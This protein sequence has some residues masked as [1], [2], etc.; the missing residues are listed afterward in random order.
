MTWQRYDY[1]SYFCNFCYDERRK[2]INGVG[3]KEIIPQI[4]I[5]ERFNL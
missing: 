5:S 1:F 4:I 3:K 2:M